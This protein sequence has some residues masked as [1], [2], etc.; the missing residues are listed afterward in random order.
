MTPRRSIPLAAA[1]L[2]TLPLPALAPHS[3]GATPA[4]DPKAVAVADQVMAALGGRDRWEALP[5]LRWTWGVAIHD[6]MRVS[7]RHAWDKHTGWHR[8]E[9]T[10]RDGRPFVIVHKLDGTGGKAWIAGRPIEGDSLKTLVAHAKSMWTNDSYWMLMPYKMRDPG[11]TLRYDGE[12]TRDGATYD[13]IAM[14]F[15]HV[16]ETPDDRYWVYVNRKT[17]RVDYWEMQLQGTKP[18]PANAT[19]EGWVQLDGLWFP[20]AHWEAGHTRNVFTRDVET[21]QSFPP[22]TFDRP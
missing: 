22:G 5:G 7:R 3:A 20:T 17:H 15:D 11:V 6:T 18:P 10:M 8:V 19:W 12:A 2:L 9:G 21:V 1:L 16:G 4:S 13:K 14:S